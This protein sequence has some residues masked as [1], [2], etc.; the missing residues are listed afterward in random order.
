MCGAV[1]F[2]CNNQFQ[3]FHFCHCEQC[4]KVTGTAYAANLFTENNNIHWLSGQEKVKR[5]D[6]EDRAIT[7]AC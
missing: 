2:E 6:V 1:A 7:R 3:H 4:Q 5:F